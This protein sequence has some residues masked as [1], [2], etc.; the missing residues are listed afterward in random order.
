M[1]SLNLGG[2]LN[3][4]ISM[5][6]EDLLVFDGMID[7]ECITDQK[8][9]FSYHHYFHKFILLWKLTNNQCVVSLS[10]PQT[11]E[12][13]QFWQPENTIIDENGETRVEYELC[14]LPPPVAMLKGSGKVG[15]NAVLTQHCHRGKGDLFKCFPSIFKCFSQALKSMIVELSSWV[16]AEKALL[17]FFF[18]LNDWYVTTATPFWL[19][20]GFSRS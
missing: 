18:R 8:L 9:H 10:A 3:I 12:D 2:V 15:E 14:P 17:D 6:T 20:F 4:P 5:E 13:F 7:Y 16:S 1:D 19:R 11:N